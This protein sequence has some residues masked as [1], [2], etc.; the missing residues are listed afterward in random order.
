MPKRTI[1]ITT[2]LTLL[3]FAS[4]IAISPLIIASPAPTTMP[5]PAPA[6]TPPTLSAGSA[7]SAAVG[8]AKWQSNPLYLIVAQRNA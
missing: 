3:A 8:S 1:I 7:L 6:P 4:G 2:A 5:T